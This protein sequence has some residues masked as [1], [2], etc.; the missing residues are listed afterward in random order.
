[1]F[2]STEL[3]GGNKHKLDALLSELVALLCVDYKLTVRDRNGKQLSFVRVSKTSSDKS[4]QNSKQWL[5]TAIGIAGSK[6]GGTFESAYRIANH[7]C[8]FYKPSILKACETQRIPICKP[9]SATEFTAMMH[10]GNIN[11]TGE[12]EV[13]KHLRA[14]HLS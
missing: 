4:F 7:L 3:A 2:D 9:M 10:A 14:R 1:M 11:G 12:R 6:H 13:M 8:R 5:D